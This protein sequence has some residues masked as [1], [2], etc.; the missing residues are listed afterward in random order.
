MKFGAAIY[1]DVMEQL[2]LKYEYF[3]FKYIPKLL[4]Q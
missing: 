1:P 2:P 3:I 4:L